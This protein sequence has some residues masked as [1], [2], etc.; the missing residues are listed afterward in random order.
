MPL[1][2]ALTVVAV[3]A[4]I[5]LT[6]MILP[7]FFDLLFVKDMS[8]EKGTAVLDAAGKIKQ[9]VDAEGIP[10]MDLRHNPNGSLFA[11][12]GI[13]SPAGRIL[14]KMGHTERSGEGLYL[15]I[16]GNRCQPLF[17]GGVDYFRL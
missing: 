14:G 4:A 5:G 7:F 15:N 3:L 2:V 6:N 9:Y 8:G 1:V 13:T 16:P 10:S 12:E 17:E 11:I